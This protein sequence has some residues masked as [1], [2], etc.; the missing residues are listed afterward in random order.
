MV[1]LVCSKF[2]KL[3]EAFAQSVAFKAEGYAGPGRKCDK[4]VQC[5]TGYVAG[6]VF[7][8]GAN[9]RSALSRCALELVSPN[10]ED[11]LTIHKDLNDR[12]LLRVEA[13]ADLIEAR[14][15]QYED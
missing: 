7:P 9:G 8:N 5:H 13:E 4:L 11:Y 15:S 1:W 6:R 2:S 14:S 3:E 10:R 12:V